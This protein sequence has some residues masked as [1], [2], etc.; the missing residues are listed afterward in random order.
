MP[1]FLINKASIKDNIA[2]I[3]GNDAKHISQVLRL[4]TGDWLMLTDGCGNRWQGKIISSST[5][6]VSASLTILPSND[7]TTEP[8][9]LAQAMIKSDRFEWIIQKSVELGCSQI[10]PFTSERTIISGSK[11]E[12][13]QKIAFEAAKQCGTA[14]RPKIEEP[15]SF[16]ELLK[17]LKQ[18]QRT[19]LFWEG[20][21]SQTLSNPKPVT[22]NSQTLLIIGPEGGFTK[23]EVN[24]A[25]EAGAVTCSLG[26]LILRVETAAIAAITLM[27]FRLGYFDRTAL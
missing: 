11:Q 16:N 25:K 6:N 10:I 27:Q 9:T 14:I 23:D 4:K 21:Q 8:I 2:T 15:I 26:P 18:F 3:S 24:S 13:W 12:R 22:R 17:R 20:E 1:Q 5:K 7:Q 19:I